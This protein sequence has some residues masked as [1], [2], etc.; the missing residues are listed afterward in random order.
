LSVLVVAL[1]VLGAV[2][3]FQDSLARH[4]RAYFWV[5]NGFLVFTLLW[6]GW[7]AG[8]QLSVLNVLTF[9]NALR[10]EFR[11]DFFLLDPLIFILWGFVAVALLFWGR[12]V[13]C[14]WLCPFGALQEISNKLAQLARIPQLRV[15]FAVHE[16][17]WPL[18]YVLFVVLFGGS[19]GGIA[20]IQSGIEVEPF[21]TAIVLHFVREWPF[22][23]Y[24]VLLLV[25]GLFV[26]RFFCRYLCPLGAALALPARIRMF[27][28]LKRRWQCGLQCHI[29]DNKCPVQ[30]IHPDGHINPNECIHC[31]NCQVLYADD[32]VCPPLV[33]RAKR[34]KS[35]LTQR[36]VERFESAERAGEEGGANAAPKRGK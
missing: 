16:R 4:R 36:L 8:A 32:T 26:E 31:L 11:W 10:T 23:A 14:G 35:Q 13:F 19:L 34:K 24:A 6:L 22:V 21:K 33:E 1:C 28:W 2:L 25:A 3:F 7:Y 20:L 18:K 30:A 9:A 5:R 29:C 17:I 12:G 27:D 15:P